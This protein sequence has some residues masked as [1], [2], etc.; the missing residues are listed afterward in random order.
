LFSIY[1][2]FIISGLMLILCGL[3]SYYYLKETP[4]DI[5]NKIKAHKVE[6]TSYISETV[7]S[8]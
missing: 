2:V 4:P 6:K 3:I 8:K 1:S 5:L 7:C